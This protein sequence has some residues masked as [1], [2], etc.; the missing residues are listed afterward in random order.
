MLHPDFQTVC[1]EAWRCVRDTP[2]YLVER[3]ARFL[4]LAAA[5][6]PAAGAILEIGSFKGRSTVALAYV[7]QHYR[8]GRVVAVDPHTSPSRT[9]PDLGSQG[10][11][12][13]EF[14]ENLR[15]AG[16]ADSVDCRRSFSQEVARTWSQP[17]RLLWIDGD[18]EYEA[19]KRD[20][21]LFRPH[22]APGAIL[23]MH[24][25]LTS[26]E[27]PQRVFLE[28]VLATDEF[29][30]AGFCKTLGWAQYRPQDGH[31]IRFR[32]RRARLAW[33]ARHVLP[34]RDPSRASGRLVLWRQKLWRGLTP[35]GAVDPASWTAQVALT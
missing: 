10:S 34:A 30:P 31:R 3:E 9:D 11:S 25:V 20:F 12:Y 32:I 1:D 5:C 16:V 19:V 14:N 21:A 6:A 23:A 2:G 29:G 24:D 15:R 22:L 27:G 17:I 33:T 35:H 4:M 13:D 8:V 26:W 18:H 7:A 28:D